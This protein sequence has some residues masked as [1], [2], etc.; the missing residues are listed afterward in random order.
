VVDIFNRV[1]SAVAP[2]ASSKK[3]GDL[4]LAKICS[5]WEGGS[6]TR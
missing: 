5:D 1:N 2:G 6:T 4:A 3:A